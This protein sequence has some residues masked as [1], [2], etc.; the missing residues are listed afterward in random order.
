MAEVFSTVV[1]ARMRSFFALATRI[2]Y[3]SAKFSCSL[4]WLCFSKA[5]LSRSTVCWEA[6][7]KPLALILA[8]SAMA[9]E[10]MTD[11]SKP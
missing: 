1:K 5:S 3:S 2:L 8:S 6:S 7:V 9:L 11:Y 10:V 4:R